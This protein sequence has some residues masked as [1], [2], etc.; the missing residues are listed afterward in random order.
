MPDF[1]DLPDAAPRGRDEEAVFA[2]DANDALV[3]R[4]KATREQFAATVVVAIDGYPVT[5]PR[6]VPATDAQGNELRAADGGPVP[7]NSTV[8]DAALRLVRDRAWT[9]ADLR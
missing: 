6:A 2:R 8:Y 1:P 9:D 4:E 5:V 3:R 7:R